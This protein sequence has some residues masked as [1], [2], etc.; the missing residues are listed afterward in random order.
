MG[1]NTEKLSKSCNTEASC[2][3]LPKELE[4][5]MCFETGDVMYFNHKTMNAIEQIKYEVKGSST[6]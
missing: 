3:Q 2:T 6:T 1:K 4:I 5:S